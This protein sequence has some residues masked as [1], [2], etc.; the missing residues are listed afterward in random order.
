M[1]VGERAYISFVKRNSK[2]FCLICQASLAHFTASNFQRHFRSLHANV[3]REFL[4]TTK[5]RKHKLITLKSQAEKQIQVFQK[6]T[7][8]SKTATLASHQVAWSIAR[9][10]KP[11]NEGE[12][13]KKCLCYIV[14][15]LSSENN[16]LK[17][18]LSD[19]QL[20][21]HT[22]ERKISDINMV[23]ESKLHS[24]FQ[25]CDFRVALDD[26]Y[27]MQDKPQLAILARFTA[28]QPIV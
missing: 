28:F 9:A 1:G 27:D 13:I 26:S 23:I 25:V 7:K 16:K 17:R 24:D 11:Y 20:S 4:K 18:M 8:H 10:K 2:P 5:L 6:I 3:N 22:V 14:E 12:F 19:V 21:R 15:I